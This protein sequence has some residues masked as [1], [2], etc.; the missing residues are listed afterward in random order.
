MI[1][2]ERAQELIERN[3]EP[4]GKENVA[5]SKALGCV[6]AEDVRAPFD[7][8]LFT[9]SAMDGFALN[10]RDTKTASSGKPVVLKVK[11]TIQAG[12]SSKPALDRGE[13]C[14]IMTGAPLPRG[15]DTV[16]VKE[17]ASVENHRL[18]LRKPLGSG[19]HIRH[20][21]EEVRKGD[22]VL[23]EGSVMDPGTMSFLASLGKSEVK[24]Y[25]KPKVSLIA[26]GSELV[27]PGQ[28]LKH[29]Q[30][31]DSN[32][33]MI[34]AALHEMGIEAGSVRMVSD[35]RKAL[36]KVLRS[37]L[38]G[39]DVVIITGGVSVGDYDYVKSVLTGFGIH[40]IFW[41]VSQKPGKPIYFG[42]KGSQLVFGLPG[43]PASVFTCFYE[44]VFPALRRLSGFKHP[45]LERKIFRLW[46]HVKPD[47]KKL[48]FL[49]GKMSFGRKDGSVVALRHQG[50]HMISSLCDTD[51]FIL[52]PPGRGMVRKGEKVSVDLLP[53]ERNTNR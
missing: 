48:L 40:S 24:I 5:L 53:R 29:G 13:A 21:G 18:I 25:R 42:K 37:A 34:R 47:P 16:L 45:Y 6:I 2:V 3:T 52:I 22:R 28:P 9:N 4:L 30:I 8:P 41:K 43:N 51:C 11:G 19:K 10:F 14:R 7:L 26:T 27:P 44:Y 23:R 39:A 50:S 49:K 38:S 36:Q 32:S 46:S 33:V 12:D 20:R 31:Y 35:R 15:A 17:E 1:T